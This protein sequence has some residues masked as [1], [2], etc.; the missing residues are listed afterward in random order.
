M[1]CARRVYREHKRL[2]GD[3]FNAW[4][5]YGLYCRDKQ[6]ASTFLEGCFKPGVLRIS[7]EEI[8]EKPLPT[9]N[10]YPQFSWKTSTV[11]PTTAETID[12]TDESTTTTKIIR[13]TKPSTTK[14]VK[15][16]KPAT[17][18]STQKSTLKTT[19][20]SKIITKSPTKVAVVTTKSPSTTR[21]P[22]VVQ[23]NNQGKPLRPTE[24]NDEFTYA[25]SKTGYK[26]TRF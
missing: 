12:V 25:I 15:V 4:V 5:V 11:P 8:H 9:V 20:I 6:Y 7:S 17:A 10:Y 16:T 23:T 3:G 14:R 1:I 2:S 21:K 24:E 19:K 22:A 26:F 13:T 18:T